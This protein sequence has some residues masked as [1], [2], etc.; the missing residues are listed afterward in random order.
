MTNTHMGE[1]DMTEFASPAERELRR[2]GDEYAAYLR[3][4]LTPERKADLVHRE[5]LS[6]DD[7]DLLAELS[8]ERYISMDPDKRA[9]VAQ[10]IDSIKLELG[11]E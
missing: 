4:N 7:L 8:G 3:A 5:V 10:R 1:V 2:V 11:G 6:N 9:L